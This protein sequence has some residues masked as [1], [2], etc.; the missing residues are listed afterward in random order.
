LE[1]QSVKIKNKTRKQ[2]IKE[3]NDNKNIMDIY[4]ATVKDWTADITRVNHIYIIF[5]SHLGTKQAKPLEGNPKAPRSKTPK[6][7]K[8]TLSHEC[9]NALSIACDVYPQCQTDL[10][11]GWPRCI[12]KYNGNF[13]HC[14]PADSTGDEVIITRLPQAS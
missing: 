11:D 4:E 12:I 6:V 14:E 9:L 2:K 1:R 7:S 5:F 13:W 3:M 8:Y 10:T